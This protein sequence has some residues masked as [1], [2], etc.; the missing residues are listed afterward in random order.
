ML[1]VWQCNWHVSKKTNEPFYIY[2]SEDILEMY[3][4]NTSSLDKPLDTPL[5]FL[6][7]EK[8]IYMPKYYDSFLI[9][10]N[11]KIYSLDHYLDY[12]GYRDST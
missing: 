7:F 8:S 6:R 11:R 4:F 5:V 2:D 10:N 1:L 9:S 3:D 12:H